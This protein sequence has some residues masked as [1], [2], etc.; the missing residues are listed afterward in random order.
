MSVE[1][2]PHTTFTD[3]ELSCFHA[4]KHILQSHKSLLPDDIH[5]ATNYITSFYTYSQG[6]IEGDPTATNVLNDTLLTRFLVY[7][8]QCGIGKF[9]LIYNKYIN[10]AIKQRDD[11]LLKRL[12]LSPKEIFVELYDNPYLSQE[13]EE[14]LMRIVSR[15]MYA[16]LLFLGKLRKK[17]ANNED[18]D[19]SELSLYCLDEVCI[20]DSKILADDLAR[21]EMSKYE[22]P[23]PLT[24]T[25]DKSSSTSSPQVYCFDTMTL[26][27][28]M[29]EEPPI[30]PITGEP[31]S[32]FTKDLL[33]K[34]FHKEI[35][36]YRRYA[37]LSPDL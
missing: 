16:M 10:D 20:Y 24:Y 36:L 22:T 5:Y 23:S 33:N 19:N 35:S 2:Q 8:N 26:I 29:T 7:I 18:I 37:E 13:D 25:V 32:E 12:L 17:L 11:L 28:I 4:V 21:A 34:R 1:F 6:L 3:Y 27:S 9:A 15:E 30:N 14:Y 31:F